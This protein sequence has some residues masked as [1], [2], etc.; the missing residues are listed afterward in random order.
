[1]FIFYSASALVINKMRDESCLWR[2]HPAVSAEGVATIHPFRRDGVNLRIVPI[3]A[4]ILGLPA[5]AHAQPISGIYIGAGAGATWREQITEGTANGT[6]LTIGSE[7]GFVGVASLGYAFNNGI[8]LEVEGNYRAG[9]IGSTA[10]TLPNGI[11]FG[12]TSGRMI[13]YGGMAN[14]LYEFNLASLGGPAISPYIGVGVGYGV[15]D[16]SRASSPSRAGV[17][18]TSAQLSGNSGSFAYQAIGGLSYSFRDYSPGLALT[19]EYRYYA[20]TGTTPSSNNYTPGSANH[21]ALL[22]LR[23]TFGATLPQPVPPPTPTPVAQHAAR[24]YLVFFD[25]NRADLTDRARQILADAASARTTLG[26]TRIEIGGHADRSGSDAYNRALSM[27]RAQAVAA[28]LTK[29]GVPRAEMA[30]QA[31][32][33]SHPLVP[34][35]DGVREPQNRRVEIILR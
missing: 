27:R 6:R 3:A 13:H 15:T 10:V 26:S 23:Y 4:L 17:R 19:L 25:W 24:T 16:F 22:G 8:R 2:R 1:M 31:F 9:P 14:A 28:E 35:A 12:S 5:I 30:I 32:G 21:S 11:Q 33:E 18:I 20:T 34:T 7:T 29:L